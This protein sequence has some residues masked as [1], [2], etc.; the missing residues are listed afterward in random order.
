MLCSKPPS[1]QATKNLDTTTGPHGAKL[2]TLL[3]VRHNPR[4]ARPNLDLLNGRQDLQ[5]LIKLDGA[6]L[7]Q[8]HLGNDLLHLRG[9]HPDAQTLQH[10]TEILLADM[11]IRMRVERRKRLLVPRQLLRHKLRPREE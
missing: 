10:P 5:E 7:L 11:A 6:V 2:F 8:R 1:I 4:K 9:R 3:K